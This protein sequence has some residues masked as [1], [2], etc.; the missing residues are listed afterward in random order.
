VWPV[1]SLDHFVLLVA[2]AVKGIRLS[3]MNIMCHGLCWVSVSCVWIDW[4]YAV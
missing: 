4:N 1:Y 2:V 3:M